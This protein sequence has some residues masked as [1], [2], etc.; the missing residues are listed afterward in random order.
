MN[1][2]KTQNLSPPKVAMHG[3]RLSG[4]TT[5][6]VCGRRGVAI[7]PHCSVRLVLCTSS[8]RKSTVEVIATP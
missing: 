5:I 4:M 8:T 3:M 7:G 1:A 2:N 6:G